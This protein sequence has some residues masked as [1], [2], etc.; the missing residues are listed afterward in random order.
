MKSLRELL[1]LGPGPSSSHTIAPYR[2]AERF[3][4]E[5]KDEGLARI[6]VL[7]RGS[8]SLTGK[9]HRTDQVLLRAFSNVPTEIVFDSDFDHLPHP[10]TM[11]VEAVTKEGKRIRETFFSLGGGAYRRMGERRKSKDVY[12]FQSFDEMKDYLRKERI[13]DVAQAIERLEG[14]EIWDFSRRLLEHSF[15]TIERGLEETS[16]LP[17]P[18]N[19][20]PVSAKV[21]R[22]AESCS[23]EGERLLLLLSA[24]AYA[25]SEENAR[26]AEVVTAPTCGSSGVVPALLYHAHR[27]GKGIEELSKAYLVGALVANFI[28]ANASLSGAV[29]GCQAEIGSACSFAAASYSY[30]MG[31]DVHQIEY[32]SEVAMEHFLGLTCDPIDGYV[33]VPCIERNAMAAVHAYTSYLFAKDICPCRENVV[34]FDNVVRAMKLTGK[35][36]PHSL[37]ETSLGGL[38]KV[39]HSC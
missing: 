30:L 2:I 3:L 10:N 11:V 5:H 28:K 13:D 20:S 7:L 19:L 22:V 26:G 12:P 32:A 35:E 14:P 33:Q 6:R 15:R 23:E 38:A 27:S 18:L 21:R 31:L 25:T 16:P 34:S 24:Y 37:K 4:S 8:L 9:G 36:L 17:G 1:L 29:L 39:I